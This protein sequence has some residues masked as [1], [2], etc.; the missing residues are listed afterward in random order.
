M[1]RRDPIAA[2]ASVSAPTLAAG[3]GGVVTVMACAKVPEGTHSPAIRERRREVVESLFESRLG[4]VFERPVV[5]RRAS[6]DDDAR[7]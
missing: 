4:A 1:V 6:A 2:S 5:V 7:A 3:C